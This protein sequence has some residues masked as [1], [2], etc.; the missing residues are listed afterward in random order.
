[1]KII[2]ISGGSGAGKSTASKGLATLLPNSLFVDVDPYF[3]EATDKLESEIFE[4]IGMKKDG[5]VLNQNYFF[6]SFESMSAWIDV[7]KDYVVQRIN[8]IVENEGKDKD[9]VIVDW[10]FLPMCDFFSKCDYTLCVKADYDK[11]FDRLTNRM[12]AVEQYSIEKGPSFWEYKQ[13]AFENRV[14]FSAINDYGYSSQYE[15]V[16]DKD[17]YNLNEKVKRFS[18]LLINEN[19]QS[20]VNAFF[21]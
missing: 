12:K 5:N 8:Y 17:L 7:I 2:G 20:S 16:N 10:C 21:N 1:M 18:N 3:R 15:I 11:R 13:W 9:F 19:M 4:A 14:K 6:T